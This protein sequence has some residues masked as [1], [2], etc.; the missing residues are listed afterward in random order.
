MKIFLFIIILIFVLWHTLAWAK[1]IA[2]NIEARKK[3]DKKIDEELQ[4]KQEE[5]KKILDKKYWYDEP[6]IS[7]KEE[8]YYL[9]N[10][11][12]EERKADWR[13]EDDWEELS[14]KLSWM[15]ALQ[16]YKEMNKKPKKATRNSCKKK[17]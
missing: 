17:K 16:K 12:K 3:R 4:E 1:T 8:V 15:M 13:W 10:K 5:K 9:Y 2:D 7:E 6:E 14:E 11:E